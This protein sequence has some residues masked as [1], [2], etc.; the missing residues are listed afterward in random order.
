MNTLTPTLNMASLM[1][2]PLIKMCIEEIRAK[3][4]DPGNDKDR[5]EL[6]WAQLLYNGDRDT[7]NG[8][9]YLL[10]AMPGTIENIVQDVFDLAWPPEKR[11]YEELQRAPC[12]VSKEKLMQLRMDD[13]FMFITNHFAPT[14]SHAVFGSLILR[15]HENKETFIERMLSMEPTIFEKA[16]EG[17]MFAVQDTHPLNALGLMDTS[18]VSHQCNVFQTDAQITACMNPGEHQTYVNS[19]S[20]PNLTEKQ[21]WVPFTVPKFYS[22]PFDSKTCWEASCKRQEHMSRYNSTRKNGSQTRKELHIVSCY[23]NGLSV[24]TKDGTLVG[25][26]SCRRGGM[27]GCTNEDLK[28]E[29]TEAI[30]FK[31][32]INHD[33]DGVPQPC[34]NVETLMDEN[35]LEEAIQEEVAMEKRLAWKR[36]YQSLDDVDRMLMDNEEDM[37]RARKHFISNFVV[38]DSK[39]LQIRQQNN[40]E[41]NM[42]MQEVEQQWKEDIWPNYKNAFKKTSHLMQKF[43]P[44]NYVPDDQGRYRRIRLQSKTGDPF[45]AAICNVCFTHF[46]RNNDKNR[47][48][49]TFLYPKMILRPDD[50]IE[51]Q[52]NHTSPSVISNNG[53]ARGV[54]QRIRF[55]WKLPPGFDSAVQTKCKNISFSEPFAKHLASSLN[56][57]FPQVSIN[58]CFEYILQSEHLLSRK[59]L[60]KSIY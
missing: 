18:I 33:M 45:E 10:N 25:Q 47:H 6:V 29:A 54:V 20:K 50:V 51:L 9:K 37:K 57:L 13:L 58:D 3:D 22:F 12:K 32:W 49:N 40:H 43:H 34:H 2:N 44:G 21:T 24:H 46:V 38:P 17:Y 14:L 60:N 59:E 52:H 7:Y 23:L 36:H 5:W 35:M 1:E 26:W 4:K 31:Y 53:I 27:T 11:L 55:P 41:Y 16:M 30:A 39:I 28:S 15:L 19:L 8:T 48:V 42:Y 56:Q